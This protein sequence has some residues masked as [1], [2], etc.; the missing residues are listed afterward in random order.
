LFDP[1]E[2]NIFSKPLSFALGELALALSG[3]SINLLVSDL[4]QLVLIPGQKQ[5][6]DA[7]VGFSP[8]EVLRVTVP[9][10]CRTSQ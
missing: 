10:S 6:S 7:D 1:S 2:C 5:S 3:K 4:K 9:T 8:A